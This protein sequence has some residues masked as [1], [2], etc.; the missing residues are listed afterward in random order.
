M[1]WRLYKDFV[2]ERGIF[3]NGDPSTLRYTIDSKEAQNWYEKNKELMVTVNIKR[4]PN[5]DVPT[6]LPLGTKELKDSEIDKQFL[7]YINKWSLST[8]MELILNRFMDNY[9]L[10]VDGIF[11]RR[12]NNY[13]KIPFQ[14]KISLWIM[15]D[16]IM[17]LFYKIPNY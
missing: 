11:Y 1:Y 8:R 7:E 5:I 13:H 6:N 9:N 16:I 12:V 17:L 15:K 2:N 4:P 3:Y 10:W 14:D